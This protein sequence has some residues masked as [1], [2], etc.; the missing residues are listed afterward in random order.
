[1]AINFGSNRRNLRTATSLIAL[2][3]QKGLKDR[4]AN[5]RR[6]NDNDLSTPYRDLVRFGP[7]TFEVY[8]ARMCTE[9][10]DR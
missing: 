6:L 8:E 4:I 3:L 1:M 9:G 10:V 5:A 2:A 7:L